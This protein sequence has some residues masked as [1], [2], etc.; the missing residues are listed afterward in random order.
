MKALRSKVLLTGCGRGG[1][2]HD[3][4]VEAA[5]NWE[6]LGL[7]RLDR[8]AGRLWIDGAAVRELEDGR[9]RWA[10]MRS[11]PPPPGASPRGQVALL[12]LFDGS[13]LARLVVSE[14]M[15]A[16][17]R[18]GDLVASGFAEIRDDLAEAVEKTLDGV[19]VKNQL[20]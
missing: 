3:M 9:P 8:A 5:E 19:Q 12:S 18:I 17:R 15:A 4:V 13:G 7:A 20:V 10:A 2:S 1:L 6:S 14:I 11:S 16:M